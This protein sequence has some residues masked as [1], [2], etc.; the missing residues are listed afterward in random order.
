MHD[1]AAYWAAARHA[2]PPKCRVPRRDGVTIDIAA[3]VHQPM[4]CLRDAER[5][6]PTQY[7]QELWCLDLAD[8]AVPQPVITHAN[9]KTAQ[10]AVSVE[11]HPEATMHHFDLILDALSQRTQRVFATA[12][13]GRARRI[14]WLR[15]R[16]IMISC[17]EKLSPT[18]C[19]RESER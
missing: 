5:F 7:G 17:C 9:S 12:Q 8:R 14:S 10:R 15:G 19:R 3:I 11:T 13:G 2:D 1:A 6:D 16:K 4:R 18:D